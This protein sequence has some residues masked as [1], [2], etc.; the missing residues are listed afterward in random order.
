MS[1]ALVASQKMRLLS[2]STTYDLL[3]PR[4]SCPHRRYTVHT[5][6]SALA[7][8]SGAKQEGQDHARADVSRSFIITNRRNT[9]SDKSTTGLCRRTRNPMTAL[10]RGDWRKCSCDER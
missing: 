10:Q 5:T 3:R 8:H 1:T 2:C 4:M 9:V 6:P 7:N